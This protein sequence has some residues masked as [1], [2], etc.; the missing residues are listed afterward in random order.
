[1]LF[2][3]GCIFA[4]FLRP[5]NKFFSIWQGHLAH[6]LRFVVCFWLGVCSLRP[7]VPPPSL[8][9]QP[10]ADRLGELPKIFLHQRLFQYFQLIKAFLERQFWFIS[11]FDEGC[12]LLLLFQRTL[13]KCSSRCNTRIIC[14]NPIFQGVKQKNGI[15]IFVYIMHPQNSPILEVERIF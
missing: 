1:M 3:P 4:Q 9:G 14:H 10:V 13:C 2:L 12:E 15:K 11:L 5:R 6:S 8:R 7:S